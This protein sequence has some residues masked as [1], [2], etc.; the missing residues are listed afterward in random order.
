MPSTIEWLRLLPLI[1]SVGA[2]FTLY[3]LLKSK[4]NKE[5]ALLASFLLSISI[6]HISYAQDYRAFSLS[7]MLT[8]LVVYFM[9]KM[10]EK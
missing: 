8:P 6:F 2:I 7:S 10:L 1:F 5:T 3:F 9:F 4:I